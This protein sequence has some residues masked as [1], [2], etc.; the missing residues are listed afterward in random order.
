VVTDFERVHRTLLEGG[1]EF[2]LIGGCAA[3]SIS[4]SKSPAT[5]VT[6]R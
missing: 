6:R 1:I 5:A 3:T 4:W 2:I